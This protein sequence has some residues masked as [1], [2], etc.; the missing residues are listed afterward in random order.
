MAV[1]ASV[2]CLTAHQKYVVPA[3]RPEKGRE[4]RKHLFGG[5][6]VKLGS[7]DMACWPTY[8]AWKNWACMSAE[9]SAWN[10]AVWA[11]LGAWMCACAPGVQER[12]YAQPGKTTKYTA[13]S[14]QIAR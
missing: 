13:R 9:N 6:K 12:L 7:V 4:G 2:P 10:L 14:C 8:I 1:T 5:Q 3:R 11:G